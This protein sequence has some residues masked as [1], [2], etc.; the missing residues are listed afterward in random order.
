MDT[1]EDTLKPGGLMIVNTSI[2]ARK[3]KRTD[4]E[5]I[6]IPLTDIANDLGLTAAANMV[7]LGAYLEYSKLLPLDHLKQVVP[8]GLKRKELAAKNVE[9][10]E[11]GAKWVRENV[12]KKATIADPVA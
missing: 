2:I 12:T 5:V 9:A 1:F 7:L 8:R 6:Y 3:T 4:I 11:I 10:V